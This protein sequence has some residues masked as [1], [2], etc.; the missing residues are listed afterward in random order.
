MIQVLQ[1]NEN[2][3]VFVCNLDRNDIV[4]ETAMEPL[5]KIVFYQHGMKNRPVDY[6]YTNMPL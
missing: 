5:P 4:L 1:N 6:P 2:V 3:H